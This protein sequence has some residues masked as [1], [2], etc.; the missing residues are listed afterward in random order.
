MDGPIQDPVVQPTQPAFDPAVIQ[1]YIQQ[2]FQEA[3]ANMP[4]PEPPPVQQPVVEPTPMDQIMRPYTEPMNLRSASAIDAATF[5]ARRSDSRSEDYVPPKYI[6]EVE[7]VH[8][9]WLQRGVTVSRTEAWAYVQ[10]KHLNEIVAE[11][12]Q[13]QQ[14]AA[15]QVQ[16]NPYVGIGSPPMGTGQVKQ[17]REMS[18]EELQQYMAEH[19]VEF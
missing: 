5:Y 9:A 19:N 12:A 10:G 1:Q 18:P 15:Q 16:Q 7:Q 14:E 4:K 2:G 8:N 17:A 6:D 13:R 11:R 3:V